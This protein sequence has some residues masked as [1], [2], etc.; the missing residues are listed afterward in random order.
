MRYKF[1]NDGDG[2][3]F[4]IP[5]ELDAEFNRLL[6]EGENDYYAEFNNKFE[7]FYTGCSPS[8]YTFTDPEYGDKSK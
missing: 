4:L 7:E 5:V 1:K 3:W 8:S 6:H 2:H